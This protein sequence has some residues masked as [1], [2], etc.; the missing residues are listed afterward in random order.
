MKQRSTQRKHEAHAYALSTIISLSGSVHGALPMVKL[1]RHQT[2]RDSIGATQATLDRLVRRELEKNR[3]SGLIET[4]TLTCPGKCVVLRSVF[5]SSIALSPWDDLH[6]RMTSAL[7]LDTSHD[8]YIGNVVWT[9]SHNKKGLCD[10][11]WAGGIVF[12]ELR[13][14]MEQTFLRYVRSEAFEGRLRADPLILHVELILAFK[15]H[16]RR[17]SLLPGARGGLTA[18]LRYTANAW[19]NSACSTNSEDSEAVLHDVSMHAGFSRLLVGARPC[20]EGSP[21]VLDGSID[22]AY[23][24]TGPYGRRAARR[25]SAPSTTQGVAR[26]TRGK[27]RSVPQ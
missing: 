22:W 10:G 26:A 11:P 5:E 15:N 13:S 27:K 21:E 3:R 7:Q 20:M 14:G 2:A 19:R 9:R 18:I 25:N 6:P 16:S 23:N 24:H 1:T 8:E 17:T 4:S 12:C